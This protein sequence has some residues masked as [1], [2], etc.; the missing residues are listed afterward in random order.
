MGRHRAPRQAGHGWQPASPA[1]SRQRPAADD[2]PLSARALLLGSVLLASLVVLVR[3]V[4]DPDVWMHLRAGSWIV[5]HRRLPDHDLFTYTVPGHR[6]TDAEYLSQVAMSLIHARAGLAGVSVVFGVLMWGGVVLAVVA[7]RPRR[8]PY[9]V[10]AA[11]LALAVVAGLPVW[12]ARP[13]VVTFF[14]LSVELLWIRRSL[15]GPS[16]AVLL[17]P[18]LMAL[19]SNLHGGWPAGLLFLGVAIVAESARWL[20]DR[21]GAAHLAH[22]K[23]LG[24][25]AVLSALAVG[26]NPNGL[27]VYVYPLQ[28]IA[29]AAQQGLIAEWQSPDFHQAVSRGFGVMLLLVVAGVAA[30]RPRL[31]DVLLVLTGTALALESVRNI[32]LFVAAATP[33]LIVTWSD[34]WRR[35]AAR[36]ALA[37]QARVAPR[38]LP[39]ATA[40]LLALTTGLVAARIAGN[41]ALQPELTRR[42]APVGAADWLAGH[43]EVGT[44]MFNEYAYGDYLAYRFFPDP[45]RRVFVFSEGV[46][47]GDAQLERYQEVAAIGPRWRDVLD[48]ARVDYVVVSRRS[49]LDVLLSG[50]P[51]WRMAYADRTAVIYLRAAA[52]S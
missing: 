2:R 22:A 3:P 41:L 17:L 48:Q 1:L 32:A 23:R 31:L 13:Q 24:G 14:L 12:E 40:G 37:P 25:V 16:R 11:G 30:G 36:W 46:V 18:A 33:V 8:Q 26:V 4:S 38:W 51:G 28:T 34:V 45:N 39:V 47:M 44:R 15:E 27:A 10:V 19:W 20:A 50:Q 52:P 29:S 5:S 35:A 7:T 9:P 43:P 6:W 49:P 21:A 42:A